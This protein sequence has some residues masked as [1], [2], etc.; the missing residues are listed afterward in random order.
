MSPQ[1]ALALLLGLTLLSWTIV[2][3]ELAL[4]GTLSPFAIANAAVFTLTLALWP[5]LTGTRVNSRGIQAAQACMECG[6]LA[7]PVPGIHFCLRC[8]AYPKA[9]RAKPSAPVA[10]TSRP[11]QH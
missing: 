3:V 10:A 5:L 7:F 9:A 1:L 6:S 4:V 8:G 11:S 2:A